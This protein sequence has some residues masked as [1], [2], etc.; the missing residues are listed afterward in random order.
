M[1]E[2]VQK[3]FAP[4]GGAAG[5]SVAAAVRVVAGVAFILFGIGKLADH[6]REAVDSTTVRE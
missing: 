5:S 6:M 4:R 2:L 3:A 1:N